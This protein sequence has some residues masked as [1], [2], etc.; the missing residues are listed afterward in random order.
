MGLLVTRGGRTALLVKPERRSSRVGRDD[1]PP[2]PA[3]G[4]GTQVSVRQVQGHM[5]MDRVDIAISKPTH[6]ALSNAP[7]SPGAGARSPDIQLSGS[8]SKMRD[9][10]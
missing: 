8:N 4:R 3:Q 1:Q 10:K 7:P 5:V 6:A 2:Y 9:V